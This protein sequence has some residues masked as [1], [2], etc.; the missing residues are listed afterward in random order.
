MLCNRHVVVGSAVVLS[1]V[2]GFVIC[3]PGAMIGGFA[4]PDGALAA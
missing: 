3:G 4:V 2:A 1:I